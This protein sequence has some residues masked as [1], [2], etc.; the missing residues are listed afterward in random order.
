MKVPREY[1][2]LPDAAVMV[3]E[4]ASRETTYG[5]NWN[6]P[7]SGIISGYEIVRMAQKAAGIRK[8]VMALGKLGLSLIGRGVPVMKEIV[9]MLYLTEEPLI[10]SRQKYEEQ[11][12]PVVATSFADGIALT[13]KELQGE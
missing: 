8:P 11:I 9:E 5:E 3:V 10:L 4:L 6:I 7:G 13:I 12:G 1:I 2:Y